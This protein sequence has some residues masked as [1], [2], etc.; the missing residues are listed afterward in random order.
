MIFEEY[1]TATGSNLSPVDL[2]QALSEAFVA[3]DRFQEGVMVRNKNSPYSL[4]PHDLCLL[5][6]NLPV[7]MCF[8]SYF[9]PYDGCRR[10]LESATSSWYN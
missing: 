1:R 6:P 7:S 4:H 10:M 8:I 5:I 9:T 3:Q 2:R